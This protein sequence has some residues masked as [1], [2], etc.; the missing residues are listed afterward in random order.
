MPDQVVTVG[1]ERGGREGVGATQ[2]LARTVLGVDR[3]AQEPLG[4]ALVPDVRDLREELQCLSDPPLRRLRPADRHLDE[5]ELHPVRRTEERE[6]V[7]IDRVA[8]PSFVRFERVRITGGERSRP[9]QGVPTDVGD[10]LAD[11]EEA[12]F[13]PSI[14]FA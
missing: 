3:L 9:H 4:D 6:P 1:H 7:A 2:E 5:R 8:P 11:G 12:M 10:G 14:V 13:T